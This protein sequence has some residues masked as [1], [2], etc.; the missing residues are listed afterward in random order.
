MN[1]PLRLLMVS[2]PGAYG[3]FIYVRSLISYLAQYHPDIQVDWAYSSCRACPE[4]PEVVRAVEARG[5]ITFDMKVGNAP[6]AGD[7]RAFLGIRRLVRQRRPAI[8]HAHSSKAGAL[9]RLGRLLGGPPVIYT[10]HCYYGMSPRTGTREV[11]FTFVER[12]LGH[13]GWSHWVSGYEREYA[14][15]MLGIRRGL[16]VYTGVDRS[17]YKVPTLEEK[18]ELRQELGL[19]REGKILVALGRHSYQKNYEPLYAALDRLL[20]EADWYFVHAGA[21]DNG[22]LHDSLC[23]AARQRHLE[24][25]YV[26]DASRLLRA[27]DGLIMTSRHEGFSLAAIEGICCGLPLILTAASGSLS[28]MRLGFPNIRW[29]PDP[30]AEANLVPAIEQAIRDWAKAP[31]PCLKEQEKLARRWLDERVQFGKI[32]KFYR[33]LDSITRGAENYV[34]G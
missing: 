8:I 6:Q 7:L 26:K 20:P 2:E 9:V 14:R 32:V 18:R 4:L 13:I 28:L 11:F 1:R 15:A 12:V 34:C 21:A 31:P 27:A 23:T 29:L 10:P 25:P 33:Y 30:A 22:V 5:G 19:P 3:V 16:L 17:R 24:L